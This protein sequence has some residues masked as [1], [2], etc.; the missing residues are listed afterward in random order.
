MEFA[1]TKSG[2]MHKYLHDV[3]LAGNKKE[4]GRF[5]VYGCTIETEAI[6]YKGILDSS[7]ETGYPDLFD[8]VEEVE[9]WWIDGGDGMILTIDENDFEL[10]AQ[11]V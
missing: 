8:T 11:E 4:D 2:E 9:E 5:A 10:I 6:F 1:K 3:V 7:N